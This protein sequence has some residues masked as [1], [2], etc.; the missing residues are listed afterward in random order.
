MDEAKMLTRIGTGGGFIAA[1]DQSGGST[2]KALKGYGDGGGRVGQRRGD[3]RPDPR[4][5]LADHHLARLHR[6]QGDRR[7]PLRADD[8][9]RDRWASG[10][11]G[12]EGARRRALH[13]D[14]QGAGG[15]GE[16]RPADEA[17]ARA[18]RV[19]EPRARPRRV[20]HQGALGDQPRQPRRHRRDRA[21]A[22]RGGA[23]GARRRPGPDHR[24][25]GEHQEPGARRS[26][27]GSCSKS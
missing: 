3:V 16:R 4:D 9:R 27:R 23:A 17:D 24:A 25:R 10:A 22:V 18:R 12:A 7:D 11:R 15:R 13:Q 1:L 14:R 6:R 19:A 21:A 2:P 5:A 26:G 20:R 8:G